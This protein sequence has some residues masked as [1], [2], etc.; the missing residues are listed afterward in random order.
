MEHFHFLLTGPSSSTCT[1][2]QTPDT[3]V[4][5]YGVVVSVTVFVIW[6]FG[7][8]SIEGAVK[9]WARVETRALSRGQHTSTEVEATEAST[10]AKASTCNA[11]LFSCN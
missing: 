1:G 10:M 9:G 6:V 8:V 3:D 4:D 7:H 11:K 2:V 5:G